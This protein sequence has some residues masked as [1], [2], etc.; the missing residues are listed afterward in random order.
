VVGSALD[1]DE[2]ARL[3]GNV[4]VVDLASGKVREGPS[5]LRRRA[6][7]FVV[8]MA[9]G[10][11]LVGGGQEPAHVVLV[12]VIA[13]RVLAWSLLAAC[14]L[15]LVLLLAKAPPRRRTI[16]LSI[17]ALLIGLVVLGFMALS[18]IRPGD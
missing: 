4:Y 3:K 2:G 9:D 11:L 12:A 8:R 6:K 10:G 5:L 15:V 17:A 1:A 18:G 14:V 16:A 7:P 13:K